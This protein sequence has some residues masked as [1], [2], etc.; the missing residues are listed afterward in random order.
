MAWTATARLGATPGGSAE[1]Q[2]AA[3]L[4]GEQGGSGQADRHVPGEGGTL[5]AGEGALGAGT[6]APQDQV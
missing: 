4:G 3:E 1:P 6:A 5:G 2:D